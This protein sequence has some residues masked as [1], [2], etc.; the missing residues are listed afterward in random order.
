MSLLYASRCEHRKGAVSQH[1]RLPLGLSFEI[2]ATG[3]SG[4]RKD[5]MSAVSLRREDAGQTS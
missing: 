5:G 3:R 4:E 1:K 2:A